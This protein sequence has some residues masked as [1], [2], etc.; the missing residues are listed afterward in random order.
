MPPMSKV[1]VSINSR[2]SLLGR[3][4]LEKLLS[5]RSDRREKPQQRIKRI[6]LTF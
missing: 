2:R 1:L 6:P 3:S 5:Q 4:F